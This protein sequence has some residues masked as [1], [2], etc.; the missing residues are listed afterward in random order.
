MGVRVKFWKGA[1]WLF[2]NHNGRRKAK[3]VGDKETALKVAQTIRERLARGDLNLGA[4][5]Q[6]QTFRVFAADWLKTAKG[7]LKASTLRFYEGNL[8]QHIYPAVGDDVV[9]SLRRA[10]CRDL[11]VQ[12]RAKGLK[13]ATVKGIARTL[14]TILS[15][16]VE[17]EL[18]PANP[19][20][21][22]GRYLR[23]GDE[24][25][26]EIHPLTR[27]EAARLLAG[28]RAHFPRWHA[29]LLCALRTGLRQGELLGLQ[30]GDLDMTSRFLLVRRNLVGGILTTPKNHQQ[31]RVDM[32]MQLKETLTAMRRQER[33]R[34]LKKG[35]R[36][37]VWV[38]PSQ[39]GTAL[40]EAN[41]RHMFYRIL[42][43]A[44]LRRIRFHDLRHTF[45][46]LLIQ[47]GES[48][49][50]VR[51]QMGHASIQITADVY[52]HLVPGA[53]RDAVDR[54]DDDRPAQPDATP[55]QPEAD[56]AHERH[57][58]KWL[59]RSGEPPRNRTENPQIKSLLL[60][61]LS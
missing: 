39:D 61:Q 34:W 4:D 52:G 20:L 27:D 18:L 10:D 11:I 40:D 47:H 23:R 37:P 3:R 26:P 51:D 60:C 5:D 53:N 25:K 15:Q 49:A 38:F 16:A 6:A 59:K 56:L 35:K 12:C 32:S 36:L 48:L 58:R 43:K 1:W 54:L 13:L 2:I 57:P 21:R 7:N 28:T 45:A 29:L 22:L 50:Y 33:A 30:W 44:E 19:A 42:E 46:S 17:D 24:P 9:S 31:R 41:V 14:S 8:K 55:A